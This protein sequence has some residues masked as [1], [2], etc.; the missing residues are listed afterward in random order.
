MPL[1]QNSGK[2][3]RRDSE[4]IG[5]I[6]RN[7]CGKEWNA[8]SPGISTRKGDPSRLHQRDDRIRG[9]ESSHETACE[10]P[11]A[12]AWFTRESAGAQFSLK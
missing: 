10:E 7:S 9:A 2:Q 4:W 1:T 6:R 3:R 12:D 8:F 11:H 5:D